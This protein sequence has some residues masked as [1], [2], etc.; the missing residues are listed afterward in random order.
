[1]KTYKER[2]LEIIKFIDWS[3]KTRSQRWLSIWSWC[4]LGEE[5]TNECKLDQRYVETHI[6]EIS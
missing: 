1:M 3:T 4:I 6:Q 5:E 2:L